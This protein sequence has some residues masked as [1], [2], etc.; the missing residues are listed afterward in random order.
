MISS[1]VSLTAIHFSSHINATISRTIIAGSWVIANFINHKTLRPTAG[2]QQRHQIVF[3]SPRFRLK[4]EM[5]RSS[6]GNSCKFHPVFQSTCLLPWK[7]ELGS[8]LLASISRLS[9]KRKSLS[10]QIGGLKWF[11]R[12]HSSAH[13]S[14]HTFTSVAGSWAWNRRTNSFAGVRQNSSN[15]N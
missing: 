11:R 1:S 3:Q 2:S 6:T 7:E 5:T 4:V 8:Q 9:H 13:R 15:R 12:R 14:T 10:G